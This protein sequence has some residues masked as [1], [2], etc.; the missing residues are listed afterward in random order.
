M[1][2]LEKEIVK[3]LMDS[4]S[5]ERT[6]VRDCYNRRLIV[7]VCSAYYSQP[8]TLIFEV[9]GSPIRGRA[10]LS[11]CSFIEAETTHEPDQWKI[12]IETRNNWKTLPTYFPGVTGAS[13]RGE[14][15]TYKFL[16]YAEFV[17]TNGEE[18]Q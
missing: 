5:T 8:S 3:Y 10:V 11:C 18:P 1:K 13:S 17:L 6:A 2:E 9:E 7:T 14:G 4:H 15:W 16:K 12:S